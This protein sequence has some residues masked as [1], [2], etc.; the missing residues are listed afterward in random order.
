MPALSAP[1]RILVDHSRDAHS[2]YALAPLEPDDRYHSTR[3]WEALSADLLRDYDVLAISGATPVPCAD[4]E[5]DAIEGFVLAGGG[6]LLAANAGAFEVAAMRPAEEMSVNHVAARFG[7]RFMCPQEARGR[8]HLSD[9]FVRGYRP[10]DLARG[11]HAAWGSLDDEEYVAEYV[12][13]LSLPEGADVLLAHRETGEPAAAAFG[14]GEGRVLVMADTGFAERYGAMCAAVCDWLAEGRAS[15]HGAAESVPD[16]IGGVGGRKKLRDVTYCYEPGCEDAVP[17]VAELIDRLVAYLRPIMRNSWQPPCMAALRRGCGEGFG[18]RHWWSAPWMVGAAD[19]ANLYRTVCGLWFRASWDM[20]V[21]HGLRRVFA[22]Q[23]PKHLALRALEAL[24]YGEVAGK[25]R[26]EALAEAEDVPP[27]FDLFRAYE[28]HPRGFW[29]LSELEAEHGPGLLEK[30]PRLL[31]EKDVL[32]GFPMPFA[33]EID[34]VVYY[35]GQAAGADLFPW[36]EEIGCSVHPLPLVPK[37]D[38]G[39]ESAMRACAEQALRSTALPVSDRMDAIE[40]LAAMNGPKKGERKQNGEEKPPAEVRPPVE[41]LSDA[42][43]HTRLVA[44]SELARRNDTRGAE[45]LSELAAA[46]DQAL[47]AMALLLLARCGDASGADRLLDLAPRQDVRFALD[48][49]YALQRLGVPGAEKL[50]LLELTMADGSRPGGIEV[51]YDGRSLDV[52][53]TV[54]GY[55]V[56]NVMHCRHE[57]RHFP[58]NTHVSSFDVG[59]VHTAPRYRRKNLARIA[60]GRAFEHRSA[61]RASCTELGTGT[62]N[63]AHTLYRSFGFTD[64]QIG[65]NAQRPLE[66]DSVVTVPEGVVIRSYKPGDEQ[67]LADLASEVRGPS[68]YESRWRAEPPGPSQIMKLAERDGQLVGVANG[69]RNDRDGWIGGVWVKEGDARAE[70]A[71]AL[72]ARVHADL[73]E[74]DAKSVRFWDPPETGYVR[75]ALAAMRY[76]IKPAGGV[77]MWGLL[78][79]PQLLAEIAPLLE[80]R[81]AD[82]DSK[83]WTGSVDLL[84]DRHRARIV[85]TEGKAAVEPVADVPA[86]IV[87]ACDDDTLTRVVSGVETPFEAYLQ[88]RLTI[89]PHVHGEITGLLETL[90]PRALHR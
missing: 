73:R 66:A 61:K 74:C 63:V 82:S 27:G 90:F 28:E 4:E 48:A 80:R 32:K 26:A 13:P 78:N 18:S 43:P 21:G 56:A 49:G 64:L 36:F 72:L 23:A 79:L 57:V 15:R 58:H 17:H 38:E 10:E 16:A 88:T 62:R 68:C 9:G 83:G 41:R 34:V 2:S 45:A 6:L 52:W 33:D 50:S 81:L 3:C 55:K 39:F 46:D 31:P 47:Q 75:E 87:I 84:G 77:W 60:M 7:V 54:E 70:I 42:D 40:A 25:L 53:P 30:L 85:F 71:A 35:L 8:T 67:A 89:E 19:A 20:G 12:S 11:A 76:P 5:L 65:W 37:D 29:A 86:T 44:A 69:G 51:R 22:E 1:I 24:G 59:W 14:F